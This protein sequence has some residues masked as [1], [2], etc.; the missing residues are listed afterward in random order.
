MNERTLATK[1]L[2]AALLSSKEAARPMA[3]TA[4]RDTMRS[5]REEV[6]PFTL[7]EGLFQEPKTM[8]GFARLSGAKR[9]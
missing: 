5:E 4:R 8:P 1:T 9:S 7:R 3:A 6:S 2:L